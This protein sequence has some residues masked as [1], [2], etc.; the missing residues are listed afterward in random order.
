MSKT[1][2][3][4][5]LIEWLLDGDPAIVY[6]T[7]TELLGES[8]SQ[9]EALQQS[10]PVVDGYI[11]DYFG[12]RNPEN[13]L[14]AEGVYL[15]KWTSTHYTML[16][17]MRMRCPG[18]YEPYQRG[19]LILLNA[20]CRHAKIWR[21]REPDICMVAM[22]GSIVCHGKTRDK[23]LDELIDYLLDH[24][25][26]DG[27]FNCSW[28]RSQVSSVH[29]TL[30]VLEFFLDYESNG[31]KYRLEEMKAVALKAEAW[32][33]ERNIYQQR[34]NGEPVHKIVT[35]LPYPTRYKFDILK[36]LEYFADKGT[37]Y[38]EGMVPALEL[39]V[40]KRLKSGAWPS[41]GN[42]G[43]EKYFD[44]KDEGRDHRMNTLRALK[45]VKAYRPEL[46]AGIE[47]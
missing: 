6:R 17:L 27:G 11:K 16:E 40:N 19:A 13:G 33:M 7:R 36:A 14:W 34:S 3:Y 29:T 20:E 21:K 28:E 24:V 44:I 38:H 26:S 2:S 18:D 15:P 32:F 22:V 25:Q 10:L 8:G 12:Y 9:V 39:L 46:I 43:R 35:N 30:T 31:Y 47:G 41:T 23:R 37:P 4:E 42:H 45:V 5:Q 1:K